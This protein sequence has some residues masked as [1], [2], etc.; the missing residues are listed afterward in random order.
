MRLLNTVRT[1]ALA[2]ALLLPLSARADKIGYFD[3]KRV[4][5]E[6][7]DAKAAKNR[8]EADVKNKQSQL[9]KQKTAIEKME[10]ELEA[11]KAVL[12]QSALQQAYA[13]YQQK[14]QTVQRLYMELQQDLAQKEQQAM[15]ELLQRL[16]PVVKQLAEAEGYSY[17]FER[18]AIF[19]GPAANDLTAQVIRKYNERYPRGAAAPKGKK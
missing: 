16:E 7:E 3:A 18:S 2:A 4:V 17:V 1:A 13:D 8:L 15:G 12:S 5:A 11:K 9:D 10:K 6:V 14:V 19:Y